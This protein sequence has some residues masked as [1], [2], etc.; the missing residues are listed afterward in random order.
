MNG[1]PAIYCSTCH[2]L[3]AIREWHDD[4]ES[5]SIEL[6][7]CGHVVLRNARVEWMPHHTAV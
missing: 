5:L 3:R 7:P 1:T 2:T 4:H 6:E